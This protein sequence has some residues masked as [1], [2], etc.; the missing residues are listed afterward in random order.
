M[1]LLLVKTA[2]KQL[3]RIPNPFRNRLEVE[4]EKLAV[5]PFPRGY[6]KLTGREGYR[7][8]MGDYRVIY[9]VSKK[10]KVVVV[11]SAQHRKDAYRYH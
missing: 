3:T 5:N 10:E 8:R 2:L 11:L 6:T 1:K 4:I 7:I 9:H